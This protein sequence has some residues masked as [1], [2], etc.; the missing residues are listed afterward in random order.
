MEA[1]IRF[2]KSQNYAKDKPLIL[3]GHSMGG[4]IT[5]KT[6]TTHSV[7]GVQC[8]ALS[9][10]ALGLTIPVPKLKERAAHLLS[11]WLPKV[12]LYN[13][14]DFNVLTRDESLV[15]E[16]KNDPLR[17]D[18]V[19]PRLFTGMTQAFEDVKNFA[20][21]IHIPIIMKLR[22][23]EK[24]VSTSVSQR[25]F[26]ILGSKRKE[27]FIYTDSYHEIFNDLDRDRVIKDL[28]GFIK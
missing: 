12:T 27:L 6:Y 2:L 10:P 26:P 3:F 23:N 21:E 25:T 8:I 4:L 5:L 19:S 13:E 22:G 28:L 16:Y 7:A 9:S 11:D 14:I 17:H 18:K 20:P 1:A 15:R 24:V